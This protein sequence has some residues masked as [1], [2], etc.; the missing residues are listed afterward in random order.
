MQQRKEK[1]EYGL[2]L[3]GAFIRRL[4]KRWF[5]AAVCL[6]MT[7]G[8]LAYIGADLFLGNRYEATALASVVPKRNTVTLVS[9]WNIN[10]ALTRSLNMWN[11]NVLW[12]EIEES[13]GGRE[14][15]GTFRATRAA[16]GIVRLW[17]TS[18]TAQEA[19]FILYS[20]IS[21][22]K[23]IVANFDQ[24]YNTVVLTRVTGDSLSVSRV[25]KLIYPVAGAA[26][27]FFGI[28]GLLFLWS[29]FTK[30]LHSES[31]ADQ[32]LAVPLYETVPLLR[33]KKRGEILL[34]N[35]NLSYSYRMR[36]EH[37]ASRLEQHLHRYKQKKVMITSIGESEGKSTIIAN[38]AISLAQ[39]DKKVLLFDF[40]LRKPA[41][42]RVFGQPRKETPGISGTLLEGGDVVSVAEPLEGVPNLSVAF[43]Y[44]PFRNPDHLYEKSDIKGMLD[45]VAEEYDYIFL[46]TAPMGPV[47]D[48]DVLAE[49]ADCTLMVARQDVANAAAINAASERLATRGAAC[50]GVIL[51]Q[52]RDMKEPIHGRRGSYGYD[53][54][55]GYGYGKGETV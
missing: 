5:L 11:S 10:S 40:D 4:W 3:D 50:A 17:A 27:V 6:A 9:D 7:V 47:R 39:R 52:C 14:I 55:Y 41:Q 53:Y 29:L 20:A 12:R 2:W 34:T 1:T 28:F 35:P 42:Y 8:I 32:V 23:A 13:A 48:A 49:S 46:D 24:S 38:L 15:K 31:Q 22:H 26:A 43:Q 33:K 36:I 30:T 16:T 19:Y 51:N 54:D 45:R 25:H 18:N 37:L 21:E 44:N